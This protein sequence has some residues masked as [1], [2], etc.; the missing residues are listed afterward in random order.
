MFVDRFQFIEVFIGLRSR[1]GQQSY[2][3]ADIGLIV[4]QYYLI[5]P[6]DALFERRTGRVHRH[7]F[8]ED[9]EARDVNGR[10]GGCL[11]LDIRI[12][13]NQAFYTAEIEIAVTAF[14]R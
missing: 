2:V 13:G 4:R 6:D 11:F 7:F 10:Y 12:K 5:R 9:G 8:I 1:I 3:K 14:Y